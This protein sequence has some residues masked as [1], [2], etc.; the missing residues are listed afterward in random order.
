MVIQNIQ[1]KYGSAVVATS[2]PYE[3]IKLK[4]NSLDVII[5]FEA[6]YYI[7]LLKNSSNSV[8]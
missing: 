2:K 4:D 5:L 6:I 8:S 3:K 7:D 1:H